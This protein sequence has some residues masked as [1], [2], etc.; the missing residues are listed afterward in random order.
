MVGGR[1]ERSCLGAGW[2]VS[3]FWCTFTSL[4]SCSSIT[5]CSSDVERYVATSYCCSHW[6]SWRFIRCGQMP[7]DW[8]RARTARF[9][10]MADLSRHSHSSY[11]S[12]MPSK[13]RISD[14]ALEP[15]GSATKSRTINDTLPGELL[16]IVFDE[17]ALE[18]DKFYRGTLSGVAIVSRS[19]RQHIVLHSNTY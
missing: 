1:L 6:T 8:R 10:T 15:N 11:I 18:E 12:W 16:A 19:R 7:F 13:E 4:P 2:E 9:S 14:S 17:C 5:I 3:G